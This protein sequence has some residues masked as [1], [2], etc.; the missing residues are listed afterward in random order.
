MKKKLLTITAFLLV[1]IS[2]NAQIRKRNVEAQ[3]ALTTNI[4]GTITLN[5]DKSPTVCVLPDNECSGRW[6]IDLFEVID[7]EQGGA[8]VNTNYTLKSL[9]GRYK[10]T[11]MDMGNRTYSYQFTSIPKNIK[12]VIAISYFEK[13]YKVDNADNTKNRIL[14]MFRQLN[15]VGAIIYDNGLQTNRNNLITMVT[16]NSPSIVRD[17]TISN[18]VVE[19]IH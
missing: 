18:A 3:K 8:F 16:D 15:L 2:T 10:Y 9:K 11:I 6:T 5:T 12:T 14:E 19:E 13:M 17:I 4:G 1:I 7:P